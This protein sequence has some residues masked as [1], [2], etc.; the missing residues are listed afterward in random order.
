MGLRR[1]KVSDSVEK[2]VAKLLETKEPRE[3]FE[4]LRAEKNPLSLSEIYKIRRRRTKAGDL[5][6]IAQQFMSQL[7]VPPPEFLRIDDFGEPGHYSISLK[8]DVFRVVWQNLG[9]GM[10]EFK[11]YKESSK[12]P[13]GDIQ[14][15]VA[16][17]HYGTLELYYPVEEHLLFQ[18]MLSSLPEPEKARED[19]DVLKLDGGEVPS[20]MPPYSS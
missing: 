20:K 1:Q 13:S 10:S 12:I 8:E 6:D 15:K 16:L 9:Y 4:I 7:C 3:V 14:T 11:V 18:D 17:S 2:Y 19:F 5:A